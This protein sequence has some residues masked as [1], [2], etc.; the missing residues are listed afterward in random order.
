MAAQEQIELGSIFH[1]SPYAPTNH[2]THTLYENFFL[3]MF[4]ISV[5]V[6]YVTLRYITDRHVRLL[7]Y[8]TLRKGG[9]Q[10][11]SHST[12]EALFFHILCICI[13]DKQIMHDCHQH[14]IITSE[15]QTE[16]QLSL[17]I[18]SILC[19]LLHVS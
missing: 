4:Q 11:L 19:N 13:K 1:I 9:N 17:E 7:R 18:A 10:A 5:V 12:D 6:F 8:V 15:S 14:N 16:A 2:N 3:R